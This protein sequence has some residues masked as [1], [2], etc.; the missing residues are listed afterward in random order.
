MTTVELAYM[1]I[2]KL[3]KSFKDMSST[4]RKAMNEHATR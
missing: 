3:V 1:E 2:E 4:D